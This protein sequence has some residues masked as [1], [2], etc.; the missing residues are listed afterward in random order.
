MKHNKYAVYFG[1]WSEV[2][3]IQAGSPNEAAIIAKSKRIRKGLH[4][5]VSVVHIWDDGKYDYVHCVEAEE[6]NWN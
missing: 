6:I 2:E 3:F 5:K 4:H 1:N